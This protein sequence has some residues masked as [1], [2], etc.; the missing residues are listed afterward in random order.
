MRIKLH[1]IMAGP[2]GALLP[3]EHEVADDV[4]LALCTSGFAESL[5]ADRPP[6]FPP[7]ESAAIQPPEHA[8][9]PKP[10]PAR[11]MPGQAKR[12]PKGE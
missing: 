5:E 10:T 6:E 4:G 3:G 8:V 9:L 12:K 7:I 2:A 11:G 1:T